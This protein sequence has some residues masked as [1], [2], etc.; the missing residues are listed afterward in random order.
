MT[1]NKIKYLIILLVFSFFTTSIS[2]AKKTSKKK[3]TKDKKRSA[4]SSKKHRR[5]NSVQTQTPTE[6]TKETL[7]KITTTD[8]K[9]TEDAVIEKQTI[10]LEAE[11]EKIESE[12]KVQNIN[13]KESNPNESKENSTP[14]I[15][16]LYP[17]K[18]KEFQLC[19]R[20]GCSAGDDQPKHVECYKASQLEEQLSN[21]N[22][23]IEDKNQRKLFEEYFTDTFLEKEKEDFCT[24][25]DAPEDLHGTWETKDKDGK[26]LLKGKCKIPIYYKRKG[27][28]RKC[29]KPKD[30]PEQNTEKTPIY[31]DIGET[32]ICSAK[33]F[34]ISVEYEDTPQCTANIVQMAMGG[35]EMGMGILQ[36]TVAGVMAATNASKKVK[37]KKQEEV[38]NGDGTTKIKETEQQIE[39]DDVQKYYKKVG[40]K[41][42]F[43]ED[44]KDGVSKDDVEDLKKKKIAAGVTEGI[45]AGLGGTMGGIG[46]MVTADMMMREKGPQI[47][48]KCVLGNGRIITEDN[49][50]KLTW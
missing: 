29:L 19:M 7:E 23:K 20:R 1:K 2:H 5:N 28:T 3:N 49:Q 35:V 33:D 44:N 25:K 42:V 30:V 16:T 40:N 11:K 8:K 24:R 21:C 10:T 13:I 45:S 12:S 31:K 18:W 26:P 43:I 34:G 27:I 39:I 47:K 48:G 32:F 41:K 38:E 37:V 4:H 6:T 14:D 9:E 17:E 50:I 46:K 22:K 36:G 15:P